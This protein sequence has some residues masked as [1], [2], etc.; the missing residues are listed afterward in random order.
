MK[1]LGLLYGQGFSLCL[2]L[3]QACHDL[4]YFQQ[5]FCFQS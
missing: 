3:D 4:L 1:V 5:V 2:I